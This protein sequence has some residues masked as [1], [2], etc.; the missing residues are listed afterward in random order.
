MLIA[1]IL[2]ARVLGV[3]EYGRF[4]LLQT[5]LIVLAGVAH[6]SFGVVISQQVAK[7]RDSDPDRAGRIAGF[8]LTVTFG[9]G[10]ILAATLVIGRE[11]LARDIFNDPELASAITLIAII[12]PFVGTSAVQQ[13][14][15]NGLARFRAQAWMSFLLVPV[16]VGA[17]YLGA[18]ELGISGALIG[19]ACAFAARFLLAQL[20]LIIVF[21]QERLSWTFS[22]S[23]ERAVGLFH[24]SG[25]ATLAGMAVSL[26]IWG[27]QTLLA[28][29]EGGDEALSL[30]NASYMLRTVIIFLPQQMVLALLPLVTRHGAAGGDKKSLLRFSAG[31]A[32]AIAV[33]AAATAALFANPLLALF[34]PGFTAGQ[35]TLLL[36]LLSAPLEALTMTIYQSL[37]SAGRFWKALFWVNAPLAATVLGVATFLV[38]ELLSLG[39]ALAWLAGWTLALALTMLA[40]RNNRDRQ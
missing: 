20:V 32:L 13:G 17:P 36:L 15:F 29:Q 39:L 10:V 21:R 6:L 16:V 33:L 27:G 4:V 28:R 24:L 9:M 19:L 7:Y 31:A 22:V 30:F 2:V 35:S 26:A 8:C 14:L 12:L 5:T 11:L 1:G 38:P 34:G 37:Q 3:Q 23:R 25:P 40:V 18:R